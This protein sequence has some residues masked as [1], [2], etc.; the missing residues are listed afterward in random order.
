MSDSLFEPDAP[1]PMA[2]RLRPLLH[3]WASRGVCF[4]TSSWKYE[5]WLGTVY[6]SE[7]YLTRRKL[8]KKKFEAECLR[9]YAEVFPTVCGDF[10]FYQFPTP[11]FWSQLFARTPAHFTFGLKVPEDVTVLRWPGHARYG[12]RSGAANEHFLDAGL[13]EKMFVNPLEPHRHQVSAFIF[14]FGTFARL[15]MP[16]VVE[17]LGRLEPF[18][19]SLPR[20]W[21][22]AVEVRNPEYLVPAYFAALARRNVAHVF[23]AWTR[24]PPLFEQIAL[25]EAFTADF[26]VVRALL[27]PGRTYESAVAMFQPYREVQAADEATRL[28]LREVALHTVKSR[29]RANVFVNNR[30]EGNAPATIAAVAESLE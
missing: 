7:R 22:Y 11:A 3:D 24:M 5:G 28:A 26:T 23:N 14:E 15:E 20:G 12:A 17:F 13:F 16:S 19:D 6:D 2:A 30:L 25:S 29:R 27:Q 8:S 1:L 9:E 18:L 10:S 4:G 21:P